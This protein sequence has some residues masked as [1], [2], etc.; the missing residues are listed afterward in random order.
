MKV[1]TA[2]EKQAM[3]RDY[4]HN[5]ASLSRF[6]TAYGLTEIAAARLIRGERPALQRERGK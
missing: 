3:Y 1:Y 6:A 4:F 2:K 5:Y